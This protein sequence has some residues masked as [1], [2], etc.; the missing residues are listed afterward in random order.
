MKKI[1]PNYSWEM[2]NSWIANT[3][4]EFETVSESEEL[5]DYT[6][7]GFHPVYLGERLHSGK[8]IILRKLGFGHF[9]TVWLALDTQQ[10][11][12]RAIKINQAKY[13]E[14]LDEELMIFDLLGT[15]GKLNFDQMSN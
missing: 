7:Q 12:F 11:V 8:Y 1:V 10:G 14:K 6:E 9:S 2:I 13:S 15:Q 4:D 5:E 3:L